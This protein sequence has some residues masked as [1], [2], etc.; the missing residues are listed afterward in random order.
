[1]KEKVKI[2]LFAD[3]IILN[4][5]IMKD[6][7]TKLP[8]LISELSKAAGYELIHILYTK[9]KLSEREIKEAVKLIFFVLFFVFFCVFF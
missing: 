4:I 7:I 5:E 3:D 9:N 1:M 8:D 6:A 2:T